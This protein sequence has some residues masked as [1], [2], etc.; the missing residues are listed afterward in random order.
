MRLATLTY[1]AKL[2]LPSDRY[3]EYIIGFQG[4]NQNN[5]NLNN[6]ETKVLPDATTNNYSVFGLLQHTFFRK[7]KLQTGIRY[8]RKSISTLSI[9]IPMD[10]MTYRPS[11]DKYYG[12]FSGS[13]GA[14]YNLTE[15]LLFRANL[16]AG[17]RT[18]NLAELT[19]KGQ[20]ELRFE[21]GDP[22]LVPENSFESDLSFHY[23][24]NNITFDLAGF[25]NMINHYIFITPTGDVTLSGIP[26][27][28][29]KQANSI[30]YGG[31]TGFHIHP[32][33]VS[34]LHF[35]TTLSSVIGTQENGDFLP[36]IP[37]HKLQYELRAEKDK[38]LF[39]HTTF[40]S[41]HILTAFNQNRPSPDETKTPGYSLLDIGTGGNIK[42]RKQMISLS[43]QLN[44]LLDKKYIDHLSTLKEVNSFN[45]GR[46][47][48]FNLSYWY[49][50]Q[51]AS[52]AGK[53]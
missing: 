41:L 44:N 42:I 33:R 39:L 51:K 26:V 27:F 36:F 11:I 43:I 4:F 17:Y 50:T 21:I 35:E 53:S 5:I 46:N 37:A 48:S 18:P 14:T 22:G 13:F 9:G 45:P 1:E 25:Y 34:W 31:E 12:S 7:L 23:H 16:A 10:S 49:L 47:I 2:Y 8:D 38:F 20:H 24:R 29:Y 6:R 28:M 3:S 19:S 40:I 52:N 15:E 30:L 32:E